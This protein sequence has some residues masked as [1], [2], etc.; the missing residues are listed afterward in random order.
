[1]RIAGL[2][3]LLGLGGFLVAASGIIPIKASSG[4]WAITRWFLQFSKTRSVATHTLAL[5]VPSLDEP[6]MVL[7][8][9]GHYETGCAPCHGSPGRPQPRVAQSMLPPPPN[10]QRIR[11]KRDDSE[12]FYIVKHGIKFTGMPAWP[13]ANR[14]DEVWSIVAFLRQLENLDAGEYDRLAQ[15]PMRPA[16]GEGAPIEDLQ[17]PEKLPEAVTDSCV[18]CHGTAG[19]G[20]GT[21]AFP[22]LAGQTPEYLRASLEA[23]A[24]GKR[25]S[26]IMGPIAAGLSPGAIDELAAYYAALTPGSGRSS[27]STNAAAVERGRA[28]AMHGFPQRGVP[29]CIECHGPREG[30]RNP[31]YPVLAGQYADYLVLQLELFR[32]Q[33]RGGTPYAHLMHFVA[34]DLRPDQM[35]DVAA[36]FESLSP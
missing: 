2:F 3:V 5:K 9:A 10:L 31:S 30:P 4:H 26:G 8:G 20:R 33:H 35:R 16:E 23:Y 24:H 7:K 17:T 21:G 19:L 22:K 13:A 18:R 32:K 15:G 36:F 1:L 34:G 27:T 6:S 12:L 29:P 25:H 14:D 28:I 11:S